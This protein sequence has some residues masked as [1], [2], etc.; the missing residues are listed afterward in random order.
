M[1]YNQD[2][3][4]PF[5]PLPGEKDGV[6]GAANGDT[7]NAAV[8]MQDEALLVRRESRLKKQLKKKIPILGWLPQYNLDWF[9]S[10]AIAG[11]TVGLTVIPQGIAYAI[12]AGLPPQYGLYSAFMGCFAYCF[13]GSSKDITI[14]PTAIMAI[15]TGAVFTGPK[16]VFGTFYAPLLAFFTGIIIFICGVLQLGFLI[17]FISQPVIAG[18]TSGAAI[19][20]ASGQI[21]SLIGLEIDHHEKSELEAGIIDYYIDIVHF[22]DTCKWEDAVLGISCAIILLLLRFLGRS[23]WF[24]PI[25]GRDCDSS[26][27]IFMN[28]MSPKALKVVEKTIWFICTARNAVIVV[29]CAVVAGFLDPDI[30]VCKQNRQNCTFTLTGSIEGGIPP[31]AFPSF[32][33]PAHSKNS[34]DPPYGLIPPE[35]IGFGEMASQLGSAFIIIPIIAI[36]ESI[37][38]AKAFA[39]GK[40]VDAS[41]EMLALGVCNMLGSMF[42]S[43]PTTGSFSRTAVNCASGVKTQMGGLYTGALVLACLAWLMPYCAFIPKATLAAVIMTAVIFSVEHEVIKP[44]WGSKKIDLVPGFVCF[45]VAIFYSLDYCIFAG[46][47]VHLVIILY[48]VARPKVVV[49]IKEIPGL[50]YLSVRPDQSVVFPSVNYLR[51][52]INKA[53]LKQGQSTLPVIIDCTKMNQSDFTAAEG[54]N[55]MLKDFKNRSQALYW[56][57]PNP[58]VAHTIRFILED[59]FHEIQS[60]QQLVRSHG[61]EEDTDHLVPLQDPDSSSPEWDVNGVRA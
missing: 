15:M 52:A 2:V 8:M 10:D 45:F 29:L 58:E 20:I 51:A 9:I 59:E 33:I 46:T 1:V 11:V 24:K 26:V 19:T 54:F 34:T 22:I 44:I 56:L 12:V 37:A 49:E 6:N 38:I 3:P 32:M 14:G 36:L 48:S 57:Q 30:D 41:Q 13:L 25:E 23:T 21:K 28:R 53:G 5:L 27:Q 35:D 4:K 16:Q 55:A 31:P 17:D 42:S 47:A 18:F 39:G 50:T 40:P 43:M 61:G 7:K 60:P